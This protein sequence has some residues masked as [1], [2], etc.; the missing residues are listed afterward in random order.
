MYCEKRISKKDNNPV[1]VSLDKWIVNEDKIM[2]PDDHLHY[3]EYEI[4]RDDRF[5]H[6]R[7]YFLFHILAEVRGWSEWGK[8][9]GGPK[10]T[11][12]D[13][14]SQIKSQI[15]AWGSDGHSHS[16]LTLEELLSFNWN[17][18]IET[19]ETFR[20]KDFDEFIKTMSSD[21]IVEH[22]VMTLD[23][24]DLKIHKVRY[25]VPYKDIVP[26]FMETI[27][28]MNS[29]INQKFHE[30]TGDIRLVFFFDN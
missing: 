19:E 25:L 3:P 1:W 4:S 10:G 8:T 23:G 24:S 13:C 22:E 30:S 15:E 12:E 6:G 14:C 27:V 21:D 5:Y 9:L 28:K 17:E 2:Y 20:S 11:P 16:Y 26:D 7:H 29:H 18:K